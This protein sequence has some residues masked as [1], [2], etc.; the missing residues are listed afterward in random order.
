MKKQIKTGILALFMCIAQQQSFAQAP[1]DWQ[2]T[3]QF[4]GYWV[5][6]A[7]LDLGGQI[8][9][10]TY[11]TDFISTLDGNGM[12]MNEWFDDPAIGSL[13]GANLIGLNATDALVHW[14]SVDNFGTAHEHTGTWVNPRHFKMVHQSDASGQIFREE[15]DFRF[16]GN[17]TRIEVTLLATLDGSAV[18]TIDGT[19]YL[20]ANGNRVAPSSNESEN[21]IIAYPNPSKE[22]VV[23][24]SKEA[25]EEISVINQLGQEIM[26][27]Y[28]NQTKSE[29][30][31]NDAGVY[32]LQIKTSS[33]IKSRKVVIEE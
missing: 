33:G 24:E 27:I 32:L 13:R 1:T 19:L 11:H 28:P 25:M 9:N 15:I 20:Q 14:F 26:V 7:E 6:A 22:F 18:Q 31:L 4:V 5:G 12:I 17:N 8:F 10:V 23:V 29:L 2:L 30:K 16:R 21:V 3:Q